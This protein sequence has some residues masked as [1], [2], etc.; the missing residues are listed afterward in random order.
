KIFEK[1]WDK[2]MIPMPFG[3][4]IFRYGDP[5]FIPHDIMKNEYPDYKREL[6]TGLDSLEEEIIE[7]FKT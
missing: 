3:K 1:S 2:F 7:E 4:I 6:K 5:V